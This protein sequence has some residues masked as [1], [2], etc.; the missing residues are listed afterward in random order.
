MRIEMA[1]ASAP[2]I[3][4]VEEF[5]EPVSIIYG[6]S[7][8]DRA[9]YGNAARREDAHLATWLLRYSATHPAALL[10]L[11]NSASRATI[12]TGLAAIGRAELPR[13]EWRVRGTV[14]P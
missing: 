2:G 8:S 11:V 5:P 14:K 9:S 13:E 10:P 4:Y 7:D 1:I 3:D 6:R 12:T